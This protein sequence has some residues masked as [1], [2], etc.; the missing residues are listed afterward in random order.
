MQLKEVRWKQTCGRVEIWAEG[1]EASEVEFQVNNDKVEDVT[2]Y[3]RRGT[4][5]KAAIYTG[6]RNRGK[7]SKKG[8]QKQRINESVPG[9]S[10]MEGGKRII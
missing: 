2:F 4:R 5:K 8:R 10:C 1:D 9:I 3:N 7:G 6:I